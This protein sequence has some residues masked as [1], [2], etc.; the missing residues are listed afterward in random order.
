MSNFIIP[1]F[2]GGVHNLV[3]PETIQKDG[4]QESSNFLTQDGRVVLVPGRE[5]WGAAGTVGATTGF[6]RGKQIDG[7]SVFFA[8]RGTAIQYKIGSGAWTNCITG[9]VATDEYTFQNYSS[10][11]GA[12]VYVNGPGGYWKIVT[13]NPGSPIDVY[14]STKNFKGYILIDKG[15]TLLWNRDKD[16]T[17]LYGSWIDRQNSTVYTTVSAEAIGAMGSTTYTGTLAFKGGGAR[18]SCFGVTFSASTGVG[19]EAF[20]EDGMGNLS[21]PAGG[22]GTINYATGAYSVTF[23]AVTTGAVTSNYLW[24]DSGVHGLTDFSHSATRVASEG[25]QFPQD[26]GGDAILNV[27]IGQ[28]GA[29][30]SLKARSAY[31]LSID[32][33]DLGAT[34]EVYRKEMGLPYFRAAIS[35]DRGI[36]FINTANPTNPKMII[37]EKSK[38]SLTV[39]PRELFK[40][41]RFSDYVYDEASYASYDRWITIFCRTPG[42]TTNDTILMCNIDENSVNPVAYSG[43]MGIQEDENFYVADSVTYSVYSIFSGFDDLGSAIDAVWIGRDELLGDPDSL[44]K[45]RKLR[46]KGYI[47]LDQT[48]GV[49]I[50]LDKQGYQKVGSIWGGA[51]YVNQLDSQAIGGNYIG[52]SQVGGVDTTNTYAYFMEIKIRTGKF[53]KICVKLVPEGIGY[54][55]FNYLEFWDT[56]FFENRLPKAFRQKQNVSLDGQSTDQ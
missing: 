19:T 4:A 31:K 8:K 5:L 37:L 2:L 29:Y 40:H 48:V 15:R 6:H 14:D 41:F 26:E 38:V 53:R 7:T 46:F 51:T 36:M 12:F 17:G 39:E 21:S 28:D 10:L 16:K 22:T 52:E 18:R 27:L 54:F 30:Y 34:N 43:K 11:A 42:S 44:K 33:D 47:G 55:N 35:T 3:D 24:E 32:A 49:Y 45:T 20:T 13:A 50:N 25:F 9:L 23:N 1:A 56:L